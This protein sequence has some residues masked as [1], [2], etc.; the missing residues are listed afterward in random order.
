MGREVLSMKFIELFAG[1]GG[2]RLGLEQAG[3]KCIWA[4]EIDP[5][6]LK[7][8][9]KNFGA[10]E[11]TKHDIR[12]VDTETIPDHDLLT[13]GFPCQAFSIAG[14]RGGFCDTRG[15]LFFEIAR[16]LSVKKPSLLLLENVSGLLSHDHGK[17]FGTILAALSELG[18]L[19]EWQV[20]NSRDFG[21]PQNRERVFLVGHLGERGFG[22]VFPIPR[23]PS[24]ASHYMQAD[25]S[26]KNYGSQQDRIYSPNGNFGTL[27]A[28]R[29]ETKVKIFTDRLQIRNLTPIECERLQSFPEGWTE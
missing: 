27:T 26:G 12:T 23:V 13:A 3:H 11:I 6:A 18:Y 2:F 10:R 19:C 7:I 24:K 15:T 8:Y 14:K 17:T 25:V 20:L 4:N 16:I 1:I 22:K 9:E 5:T 28:Y 29:T 21:V